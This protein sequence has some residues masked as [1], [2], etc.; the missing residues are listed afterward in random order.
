MGVPP[1]RAAACTSGERGSDGACA[2][3][4]ENGAPNRPIWLQSLLLRAY[5]TTRPTILARFVAAAAAFAPLPLPKYRLA[6]PE[7][8]GCCV[9]SI[10]ADFSIFLDPI[11]G[12]LSFCSKRSTFGR[13]IF[14]AQTA[15]SSNS[16]APEVY[17]KNC[18]E[19]FGRVWMARSALARTAPCGQVWDTES[20]KY[21]LPGAVWQCFDPFE[22][23]AETPSS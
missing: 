4:R 20:S 18:F 13:K 6:I 9:M 10:F 5:G 2:R 1:R 16:S 15:M 14:F 12:A 7:G 19:F 17:Q 23:L 11:G 21:P 3:S 22:N 8:G